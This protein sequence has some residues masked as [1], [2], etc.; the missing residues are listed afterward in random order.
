MRITSAHKLWIQQTLAC[1]KA[2]NKINIHSKFY[3]WIIFYS[4]AIL[5]IKWNIKL[6]EKDD[7]QEESLKNMVLKMKEARGGGRKNKHDMVT[8]DHQLTL[9][10]YFCLFIFS[11]FK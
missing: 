6:K 11:H 3:N 2:N 5:E 8:F 7:G 1:W 4:C 10:I 9:T